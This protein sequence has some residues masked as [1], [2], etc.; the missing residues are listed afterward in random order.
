MK[1]KDMAIDYTKKKFLVI[2]DFMDM[3]SMIKHMVE[4]YGATK[5]D[6]AANGKGAIELLANNTY[7]IMLCDYNLGDGMDGQQVLEEAKHK[8]L[9]KFST[10]VIMITA[11]N[12]REMVM[13]AV[14]YQPDDYLSK[15]FNKHMLRDRLEKVIAKKSDFEKI[16]RAIEKQK[17]AEAIVL[18]EQRILEKP[19]N[20]SEFMRLAADLH[21]K[22]GRYDEAAAIYSSVLATRDISWAQLGLGKTQFHKNSFMEA[23]ELFENIISEN[24]TYMEAYDWLAKTMVK[25]GDLTEAENVIKSAVEKSPK[26]ILRQMALG[27]IA[28]KKKDFSVAEKAFKKAVTLGRHSVHKNPANYT[29]QAKAL[30]FNS[31]GKEAVKVIAKLR[32]EFPDDKDA[33]LHA[34]MAENVVYKEMG[35]D[36]AAEKAFSEAQD[37]Y[38][39]IGDKASSDIS[40]EMA[41]VFY[42]NGE[43]DK[44]SEIIKKIVQNQHEDEDALRDI[45]DVF[46]SIG[47]EDEGKDII[48]TSK[49]DVIKL[50][51][52]GVQL[53]KQGKLDDAI[54]LFEKA[55]EELE[56]NKVINLNLTRVLL[57]SMEQNGKVDS[58]LYK[59]RQCMLRV[60]KIDPL[61]NSIPGLRD[62][63]EKIMQKAS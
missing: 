26:A 29:N 17:Y 25:L 57:S 22:M 23:R 44:G 54:D 43:K 39:E 13:G 20:L 62:R 6:T 8:N 7:D 42:A 46:N 32:K 9:L 49:D 47:M 37:L 18:C 53:G 31:G 41:Q 55:L 48:A 10:A 34:A 19:K 14:E 28:L 36:D 60:E 59:A 45:Q 50:N 3:R 35:K 30:A 1:T 58:Q 2:D 5:V 21:M 40:V 33:S 61:N 24:E 15:P 27:D 52:E 4:S 56:G 63:Y 11:E 16:E 12:T 38:N 51:N